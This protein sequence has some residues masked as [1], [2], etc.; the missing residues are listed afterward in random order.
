[1]KKFL[2]HAAGA[3]LE[4]ALVAILITGLVVGTTFAA[5]GGGGGGGKPSGGGTPTTGA[6][7]VTPSTVAVGGMYTINGS[8]FKAGELLN[9]WIT[10][11]HG[12]QTLFPPVSSTGAFTATSYASW[13]G[14]YTV[15][16]YD[17][18]GRSMVYLT[19]CSFS[20]A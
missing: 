11:S 7:S 12:T 4:G 3:V 14:G 18:G 20:A 1:M 6:C 13:A 17:N 15:K 2:S 5:K 16:V 19:S 10:D 9:V 8:G